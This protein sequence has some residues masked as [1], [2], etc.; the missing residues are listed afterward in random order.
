MCGYG[1]Q[2]LGCVCVCM[3][4]GVRGCVCGTQELGSVCV[5][6]SGVRVCVCMGIRS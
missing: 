3:E 4:S 1:S 2:E 6:E 5:W